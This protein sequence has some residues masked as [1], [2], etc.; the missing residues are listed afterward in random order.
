MSI[1]SISSQLLYTKFDAG[2]ANT[3]LASESRNNMT[4]P[5]PTHDVYGRENLCQ[6]SLFSLFPGNP[7]CV[8]KGLLDTETQMRPAYW[9]YIGDCNGLGQG[10]A[11][12][13]N[14]MVLGYPGTGYVFDIQKQALQDVPCNS[15]KCDNS[16]NA[17]KSFKNYDHLRKHNYHTITQDF[18]SNS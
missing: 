1:A 5:P 2:K 18:T 6:N 15:L 17:C 7:D 8:F 13:N 16:R 11:G 3:Q 12:G 9:R 14:Q 10:Y 4:I